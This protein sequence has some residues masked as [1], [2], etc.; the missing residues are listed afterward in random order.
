MKEHGMA[1]LT[2]AHKYDIPDLKRVCEM[3]V[4][5]AVHPSNVLEILQQARLYDAALVKKACVECI[6]QNLKQVAYTEEFRNLIYRNDDP[7]A[8]LDTIQIIAASQ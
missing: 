3:A 8:I 4:A 2:A 5:N 6:A 1:L 7:E